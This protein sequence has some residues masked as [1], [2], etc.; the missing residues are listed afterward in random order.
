MQ[1]MWVYLWEAG[2]DRVDGE[3][4]KIREGGVD[5]GI[6]LLT[7]QEETGQGSM[8]RRKRATP[9]WGTRVREEMIEAEERRSSW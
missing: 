1:Q 6:Q 7:Q 3:R 4:L 2:K 9:S 8:Q 5:G